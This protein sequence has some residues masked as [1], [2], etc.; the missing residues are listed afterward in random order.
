V[1]AASPSKHLRCIRTLRARGGGPH[2]VPGRLA[3]LWG[4]DKC[5]DAEARARGVA[6]GHCAAPDAQ[7]DVCL[8]FVHCRPPPGMMPPQG[9]LPPPMGGG[10]PFLDGPPPR[11]GGGPPPEHLPLQGNRPGSAVLDLC[12]VRSMCSRPAEGA[13]DAFVV[14]MI[15]RGSADSLAA[16]CGV[17]ERPL[18]TA[19]EGH[20]CC[21]LCRTTRSCSRRSS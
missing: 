21:S 17:Q 13:A 12:M 15:R 5:L 10:P 8:G 18:P 14:V 6:R 2:R 7:A 19:Q 20:P 9:R 4:D 16:S 3:T 1:G 11:F